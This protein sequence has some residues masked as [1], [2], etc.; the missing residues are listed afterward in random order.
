VLMDSSLRC[1]LFWRERENKRDKME[2]AV[3]DRHPA[4]AAITVTKQTKQTTTK[5]A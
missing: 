1:L 2:C 3:N 4:R 5:K